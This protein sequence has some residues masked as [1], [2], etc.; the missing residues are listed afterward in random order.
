MDGNT[1]NLNNSGFGTTTG[2]EGQTPGQAGTPSPS[3]GGTTGGTAETAAT[4]IDDNIL[5]QDILAQAENFGSQLTTAE[6]PPSPYVTYSDQP[7]LTHPTI[8]DPSLAN[9][10]LT[11]IL[12]PDPEK[13]QQFIQ[14]LLPAQTF[15][16][17]TDELQQL[18]NVVVTDPEINEL[19]QKT[20]VPAGIIQNNVKNEQQSTFAKLVSQLPPNVADQLTFAQYVPGGATNLSPQLQA[21]LQNINQQVQQSIAQNFGFS[22]NWPGLPTDSTDFL[23]QLGLETSNHFDN[24]VNEEVKKG[25]ISESDARGLTAME[26]GLAKGS[27]ALQNLFNTIQQQVI[28]QLQAKYHFDP[29]F[30]PQP[31]V[32]F[33]NNVVNGEFAQNY[34][35]NVAKYTGTAT[36]E[37]QELLKQYT[38][39]PNDPSIPTSI[40]QLAQRIAADQ[41][42]LLQAFPDPDNSSLPDDLKSIAKQLMTESKDMVIAARGLDLTWQPTMT[43][44]YPSGLDPKVIN[45]G[46]IGIAYVR[47]ISENAEKVVNRMQNSLEKGV[48]IDYLRT[49]GDALNKMEDC[50][51]AMQASQSNMSK[52]MNQAKLVSQLD[53][54]AKQQ[55]SIKQAEDKEKKMA[56]LGPLGK[57]FEWIIK[58][59]MIIITLPI[60]GANAAVMFYVADSAH[61]EMTGQK[62]LV[63]QMFTVIAKSL[64]TAAASIV[65]F[66]LAAAA[67]VMTANPLLGMQLLGTDSQFIQLAV[68]AGGGSKEDQQLAGM[69]FNLTLQLAA[70][71]VLTIVTGGAGAEAMLGEVAEVTAEVTEETTQTTLGV[72]KELIEG[73]EMAGKLSGES[74]EVVQGTTKAGNL[75]SKSLEEETDVTSETFIEEQ[76]NEVDT[77]GEKVDVAPEKDPALQSIS[78]TQKAI[79]FAT[80][81]IVTSLTIS[82]SGIQLNNNILLSQMDIIKGEAKAFQEKVEALIAVMKKVVD[83]L[84]QLLQKGSSDIASINNLQGK[85]WSDASQILSQI[86]G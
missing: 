13:I 9:N 34:Q 60:P 85:K 21:Q 44:L 82:Q 40:K 64:P 18:A 36:A 24:A 30:Q 33:Y 39:N 47:E 61:S 32:L 49:I 57:I 12:N 86:A 71:I 25:T 52:V 27:P 16:S 51:Y 50:I 55:K 10:V 62:S 81:I 5:W 7:N 48:F 65:N 26:N 79:R 38:A 43:S 37:Q 6:N 76:Q 17:T 63:D 29:G 2:W 8:N 80:D 56:S 69:I 3:T 11:L 54:L 15:G 35:K 46:L 42:L 67:S 77:I 28:A 59:I 4:M 53:N 14:S 22:N 78:N 41:R 73:G 20:G 72:T 84:L 1:T 45:Q 23:N 31:E 68:Q 58:I 83:M 19:A 74:S 70:I 66:L 75:A